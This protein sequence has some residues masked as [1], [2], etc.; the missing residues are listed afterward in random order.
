[1]NILTLIR[2]CQKAVGATADGLAGPETW[3]KIH[4]AL[5][6]AKEKPGVPSPDTDKD[7]D[8]DTDKVDDRSEK[9]IATLLPQVRPY[10]RA[11]V[12]LAKEHGIT[13]KIISGTRTAAEQNALYAQG[14]T[15][16]GNI[17]TNAK[18]GQSNHNHGIAFDIAVWR[19]SIVVWDGP[20]YDACGAI[21]K[22]LGLDWGGSWTSFK[23]KPHYQLRPT[24]ANGMSESAML[25]E[26]RAGKKFG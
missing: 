12:R 5:I 3:R 10:A 18:A 2:E 26:F 1:M 24:W 21:G 25:K 14:R 6:P 23:D 22:S 20:E 4:A 7:T 15:K 8:T 16:P 11:L 17:V 9:N 13:V 19:G